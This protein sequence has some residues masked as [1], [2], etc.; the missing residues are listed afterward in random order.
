MH[1]AAIRK[2]C[3]GCDEVIWSHLLV[4]MSEGGSNFNKSSES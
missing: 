2:V 3:L 1:V 4:C